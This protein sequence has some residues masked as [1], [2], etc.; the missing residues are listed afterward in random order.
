MAQP[1]L[2]TERLVLVP[3]ADEHL[4]LEVELDSDPEVLRFLFG[5]A[6]SRDEVA[7]AHERRMAAAVPVDG[8]G[9]WM[10]FTPEDD[11]VGLMMLPPTDQPGA[12]ELGYRLL[13]R[14][15][16]Q[17]LASEASRALLAHGFD[18]VGLAR[19][20]ATTMTVNTG[21]RRVM[22]RLGMRYVRTFHLEF[23]DPVP[24]TEQGEVEYEITRSGWAG[25]PPR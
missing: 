21:S 11:F 9:N 22:E 16:R 20:I 13:R 7:V 6:R 15:W 17:G 14:H 18:T 8:L 25:R 24:G 1:V 3:L 2:R 12:A 23:D 10:A 5:R 19:V 4:D